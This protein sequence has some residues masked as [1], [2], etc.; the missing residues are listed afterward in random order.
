MTGRF[1][2]RLGV[3]ALAAATAWVALWSWGGL[4]EQPGH[5]LSP[6]LLGA[7]LVVVVG[8]GG[9]TL[10]WPWYAVLLAQLLV[11]AFWLDHRYAGAAAVG[12]WI[13]TGSSIRGLADQIHAG[14]VS[15]NTFASPVSSDH[16]EVYVYLLST[17]LL[18]LLSTDLL[19]CGLRRVPWAGLPIIVTLTVPISVLDSRLSWVVF[20]VT[21]LLFVMLLATEE[22]E[23]VLGW[24]RSVA[25]RGERIDS[26]DQVVNGSSIRG[27]AFRIGAL[28]AVGALVI[29]VFVPVTTGLLKGGNG[30]GNGSGGRNNVALHNPIV[31]LRR[32]LVS[33][34]H[35]PLVRASTTGDPSYLR[36]T[37]L[38]KFDGTEWSPSERSL[39]SSND[40]DGDLPYA[41]GLSR[42]I[43]GKEDHWHIQLLDAFHSTWLP[44]PYPTLS[45]DVNR[46]DWRYDL[47]TL[48]IATVDKTDTAGLS[49]DLTGFSPEWSGTRMQLA[50]SP[51]PE[52]GGPMTAVPGNR[53]SVITRTAQEVT[54]NAT[55]DYDRMVLLQNWFRSSG[56]FTYSLQPASGNGIDAL[57]RFITTDK[58]GYCEQ[59][60][61]AMAVMARTLD[62]PARVVVGFLGPAKQEPDG[63]YLYTSDELHAWPEMYFGG[64][65]WVR[66][67]PTP[68]TRTGNPPAWTTGANQQ[69]PTTVP[70]TSSA[71]NLAPSK[72]PTT[73]TQ[74]TKTGSSSSGGTF[75]VAWLAALALV[76]I[77]LALPRVARDRQ[78]RRRLDDHRSG[79][80]STDADVLADGAWEELLAT[81]RDLV[82]PLPLHRS[83]REIAGVLRRRAQPGSDPERQ[84]DELTLFVERARYGRPFEVTADERQAVIEAVEAW[85]GVLAGSVP[86]RRARIAKVFPRSVLDRTPP[87]TTD[88][89]V[90]LAGVH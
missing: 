68:A 29:P 46:G 41:P 27:T 69:T 77:L 13:P 56:G 12:G 33:R 8:A 31:D 3:S 17:S 49:Y 36:L 48:D 62:V 45:I 81:A 20:V 66:F 11:L 51:P 59:F 89:Q 16:A 10:R 23:R 21:A 86:P 50:L 80:R 43:P 54:A 55:N 15:V 53:P 88:R 90:E 57:V 78:R 85:A 63:T 65:G 38:D 30:P 37:V 35:I 19:A 73:S 6:A 5:F 44:T 28:T 18:V 22:T 70:S 79:P 1:V 34:D 74:R 2:T 82:I 71:P 47:R 75:E 67:D 84:L 60:A 72:A 42:T 52:I 40:A 7:L 25:G 87:M 24:G 14:A 39:A 58:V 83:V 26:L 4:V 64:S 9:R 76:L 61:A 32:D